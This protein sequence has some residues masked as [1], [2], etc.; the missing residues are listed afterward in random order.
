MIPLPIGMGQIEFGH[1]LGLSDLDESQSVE[2]IPDTMYYK[3]LYK[4]YEEC[5]K[6]D[7]ECDD[8]WGI[9]YTYDSGS[10]PPPAPPLSQVS[11]FSLTRN[12]PLST[13]LIGNYPNPF[14]PDTWI[15]YKLAQESNVTIK[16]YDA[17][18]KLVR[19]MQ[20]GVKPAGVYIDKESA[21]Y[22]DGKTDTGEEVSSGVYF[23]SL[24]ADQ[25]IYTKKMVIAK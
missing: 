14:N 3:I 4:K 13:E 8:R 17:M 9:W 24:L 21:A 11:E 15:A 25:V 2:Y 22:W 6:E 18:G 7:L 23:Y 20:L 16:I 10:V 5:K 12:L 1:C 19:T